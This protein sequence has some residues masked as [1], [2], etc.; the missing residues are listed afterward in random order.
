MA[1]AISVWRSLLFSASIGDQY[2]VHDDCYKCPA[3]V[4]V[5][6]GI[7]IARADSALS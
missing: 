5:C 1:C 7:R 3:E 2:V 6:I 4:D